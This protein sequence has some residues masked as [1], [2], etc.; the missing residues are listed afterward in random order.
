MTSRELV[1]HTLN[2]QATP[3]APRDLWISPD[4]EAAQPDAV[5][6]IG[7]RFPND[8]AQPEV[9]PPHGKRSHG[10]PHKVGEYADAW[11]CG[12]QIAHKGA[13]PE[14]TFSPL[15][16][17][18]KL[19]EYHP[20]LE[21][22]DAA[23]FARVNKSCEGTHRFVL[24]WSEVRPFDRLRNLR[25]EAALIDLARGTKENRALLAMLHEFFCKELEIW[26]N[27]EVDG[28][29]F[30][31][32]WG[33]DDSLLLAPEMWREIFKPLYRDYCNILHARDKFVF[34]R[35]QGNIGVVFGDLLKIGID[36]VHAEFHKMD[37]EKLA[38][39]FRGRAT[40]WGDIDPQLLLAPNVAQ[41]KEGVLKMRRA[42]DYGSGGVIVQC[43]WNPGVPLQTIAAVFEQWLTPLSMRE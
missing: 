40:F 15:A 4:L 14:L 13:A 43:P 20:P 21:L 1:I 22:L 5:A 32:D 23:R 17:T 19:A 8:I 12:W 31:D 38:R 27:S 3:R 9:A 11:G 25:G 33:G 26:A 34:F 35:S 41:V 18:A 7:I 2:H 6:E 42:L 29:M 39:R 36:A 30:R 10:K 24:A 37:V 28:V 16:G